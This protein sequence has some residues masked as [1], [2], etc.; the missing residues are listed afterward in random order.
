MLAVLLSN[1][2]ISR[3]P[4]S[5]TFAIKDKKLDLDDE[6]FSDKK[7]TKKQRK[8]WQIDGKLP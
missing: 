7:R 1:I 6:K 5:T 8:T 3:I 2:S 4:K